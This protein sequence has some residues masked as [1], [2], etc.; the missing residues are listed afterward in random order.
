MDLRKI[1]GFQAKCLHCIL[2]IPPPYTRRISNATVLQSSRCKLLSTILKFKQLLLYQSIATLP[3]SEDDASR[4]H[5]RPKRMSVS[6]VYRT[7]VEIAEGSNMLGDLYSVMRQVA[8]ESSLLL[9]L[10]RLITPL[11]FPADVS[12]C[13]LKKWMFPGYI[14]GSQIGPRHTGLKKTSINEKHKRWLCDVKN[15]Q[16]SRTG[17]L[18]KHQAV[19]HRLK[20]L[21]WLWG[22]H[23]IIAHTKLSLAQRR[24]RTIAP[25]HAT[26]PRQRANVRIC[27][28]NYKHKTSKEFPT[29]R[30]QNSLM[31]FCFFHWSG[32]VRDYD[33]G[34]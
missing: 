31:K 22:P 20:E 4:R 27:T 18:K 16:G 9:F 13:R 30:S 14:Q 8:L 7:A 34:P 32:S 29:H 6:E 3:E 12:R 15:K 10:A 19:Q 24:P 33:L 5:G 1:H 11:A 21:E 2:G 28:F 26:Q 17:G 23:A 25:S